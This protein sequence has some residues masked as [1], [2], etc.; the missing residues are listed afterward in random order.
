MRPRIVVTRERPWRKAYV[1]A[2]AAGLLAVAAWGLFSYTRATTVS[3]FQRAQLE[4]ETLRDERRQLSRELREARA[5]VTRLREQV[6]YVQRSTEIDVQACDGVRASL[7]ELQAETADLREQLAFYRG[8]VS[9]EQARAGVRVHELKFAPTD[10]AGRYRY[11]LILIQSVRHDRRVDGRIDV[12]LVGQQEAEER[13]YSLSEL[14]TTGAGNL[15]FSLKYFEEFSGTLNLPRGFTPARV[16]VTLVPGAGGAPKI[17]ESFEWNR[18]N[19]GG[20]A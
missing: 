5:E 3:D 11:D 1:L 12:Q 20:G 9:P 2:A 7:G 4:V 10:T 19:S 18:V 8:I 6:V 15:V 17:E 14:D 16:V 13:R